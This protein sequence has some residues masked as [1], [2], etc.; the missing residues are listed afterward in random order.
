[1]NGG[2]RFQPVQLSPPFRLPPPPR[3]S[4]RTTVRYGTVLHCTYHVGRPA[5]PLARHGFVELLRRGHAGRS[6]LLL[7]QTTSVDG[8]TDDEDETRSRRPTTRNHLH[9]GFGIS[10]LPTRPDDERTIEP[11][12]ASRESW[13]VERV[14]AIVLF[15]SFV[16]WLVVDL[17]T[18]PHSAPPRHPTESLGRGVGEVRCAGGARPFLP[19]A[20]PSSQLHRLLGGE[21]GGRSSRSSRARLSLPLPPWSPLA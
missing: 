17:S 16:G 9:E 10:G 15:G 20:A 4:N 19:C 5:L 2:S 18:C 7:R 1:M 11:P 12:A 13:G 6:L 8:Y 3:R 14:D 21:V